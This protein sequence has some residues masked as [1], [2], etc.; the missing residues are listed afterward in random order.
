MT[1]R[2]PKSSFQKHPNRS[3]VLQAGIEWLVHQRELQT[4]A[5]SN[6]P[7]RKEA[8]LPPVG[9]KHDVNMKVNV[10]FECSTTSC[11]LL[12]LNLFCCSPQ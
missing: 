4:Q 9:V 11:V 5:Q 12:Y 3:R 2:K 1:S 8:T 7:H 10:D 6:T